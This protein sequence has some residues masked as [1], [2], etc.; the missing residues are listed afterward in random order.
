MYAVCS[1]WAR[2]HFM[3]AMSAVMLT[4]T[5]VLPL[6]D[7]VMQIE[8]AIRST[9]GQRTST[10]HNKLFVDIQT[11]VQVHGLRRGPVPGH[12]FSSILGA[13]SRRI[14]TIKYILFG[15]SSPL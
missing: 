15:L 14:G 2:Q 8:H 9:S 4:K 13:I 5:R 1:V 11:K 3:A 12:G 7:A 6:E 10:T